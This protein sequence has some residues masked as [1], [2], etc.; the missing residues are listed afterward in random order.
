[1]CDSSCSVRTCAWLEVLFGAIFGI[2]A[3]VLYA[4]YP[5]WMLCSIIWPVFCF[6]VVLLILYI[7]MLTCA[8]HG[9]E[10][11]HACI[12]DCGRSFLYAIVGSIVMALI[13]MTIPWE[14]YWV[15]IFVL[16]L[17]VAFLAAMITG[18]LRTLVCIIRRLCDRPRR[19]RDCDDEEDSENLADRRR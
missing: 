19:C 13:A 16:G 5:C 6:S 17:V 4:F 1:M 9:R 3:A 18:L 7:A 2:M 12:C 8:V 14:C 15:N 10:G 11:R